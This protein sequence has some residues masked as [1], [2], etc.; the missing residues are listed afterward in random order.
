MY[1]CYIFEQGEYSNIGKYGISM[2]GFISL[3]KG[4]VLAKIQ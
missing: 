3:N 1:I 4:H 2:L